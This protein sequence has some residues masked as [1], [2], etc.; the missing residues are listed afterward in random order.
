MLKI[1][2]KELTFQGMRDPMNEL[3]NE[4]VEKLRQIIDRVY[5]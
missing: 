2:L 3:A 4:E 5:A 1:F